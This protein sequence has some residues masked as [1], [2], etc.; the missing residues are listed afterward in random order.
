MKY[1]KIAAGAPRAVA[2]RR[3]AETWKMTSVK[4]IWLS[5][6]NYRFETSAEVSLY[7][8]L[9]TPPSNN[10]SPRRI[11]YRGL[12]PS[13]SLSS[14]SSESSARWPYF[15]RR[16]RR[17]TKIK[18]SDPQCEMNDRINIYKTSH[19]SVTN[20]FQKCFTALSATKMH[21]FHRVSRVYLFIQHHEVLFISF[22]MLEGR[23]PINSIANISSILVLRV[24]TRRM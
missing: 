11:R 20:S 12:A 9:R 23:E 22:S 21:R 17:E 16:V 4:L 18:S 6:L 19:L 1:R 24:A 8:A 10:H 14:S 13:S 7:T 5:D 2:R 15:L 3:A